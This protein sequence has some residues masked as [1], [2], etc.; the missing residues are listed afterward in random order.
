MAGVRAAAVPDNDITVL[1][2]N[3]NNLAFALVTPL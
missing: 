2:E 3:I 1:G